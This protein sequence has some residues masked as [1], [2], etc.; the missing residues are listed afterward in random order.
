MVNRWYDFEVIGEAWISHFTV[1]CLFN[2]IEAITCYCYCSLWG[3]EFTNDFFYYGYHVKYA[4]Q[5]TSVCVL[6]LGVSW[7]CAGSGDSVCCVFWSFDNKCCWTPVLFVGPV[8]YCYHLSFSECR[9]YV[10]FWGIDE[11]EWCNTQGFCQ[12]GGWN[13]PLGM[14]SCWFYRRRSDG[15]YLRGYAIIRRVEDGSIVC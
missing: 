2:C 9:C 6:V 1:R 3:V 13:S 7:T 4:R 15:F 12:R 14:T 11:W 5:F 10:G 8:Y